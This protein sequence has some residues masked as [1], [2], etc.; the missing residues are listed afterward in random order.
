MTSLSEREPIAVLS[1]IVGSS[2]G[3][4]AANGEENI[5]VRGPHWGI[6]YHGRAKLP[7]EEIVELAG[8]PFTF[9][10]PGKMMHR[11]N[12][13][14]LDYVDGEFEVTRRAI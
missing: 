7:P 11:L 6:G 2:W 3:E 8:I 5:H 10:V 4:I 13:A 1:W 9:A 12:G 14:T